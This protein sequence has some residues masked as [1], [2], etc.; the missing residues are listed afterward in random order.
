LQPI[1]YSTQ[2]ISYEINNFIIEAKE[3]LENVD[4]KIVNYDFVQISGKRIQFAY[5]LNFTKTEGATSVKGYANG[6]VL[7]DS[8]T[9]IKGLTLR[10]AWLVW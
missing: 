5:S 6:K 2:A 10:Q 3:N 1:T 7:S 8:F 4:A 9:Y